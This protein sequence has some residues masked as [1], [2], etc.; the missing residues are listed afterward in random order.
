MAANRPTSGPHAGYHQ[1]WRIAGALNM[2]RTSRIP[3]PV[4]SVRRVMY[5]LKNWC[6]V[7]PI[8]E[9]RH[10]TELTMAPVAER[11]LARRSAS[12]SQDNS[13]RPHRLVAQDVGFSVRKPGFD[14]PWGYLEGRGKP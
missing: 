5:E 3:A 13:P 2:P 12:R 4:D 14:S 10:R 8:K 1:A 7:E 9:R 11:T 6:G